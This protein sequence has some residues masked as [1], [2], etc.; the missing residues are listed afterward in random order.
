LVGAFELV[1]F[2]I[3]NSTTGYGPIIQPEF[4]TFRDA[5]RW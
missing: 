5:D 4:V 3:P 1:S 2:P